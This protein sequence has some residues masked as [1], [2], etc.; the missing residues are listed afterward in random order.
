MYII[1]ADWVLR[2]GP[3][4]ND[5]YDY[6]IAAGKHKNNV[7]V[8]TRNITRFDELYDAEVQ[9]WLKEHTSSIRREEHPDGCQYYKPHDFC[10]DQN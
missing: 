10:T 9:G 1:L 5:Q 6:L 3:V 4:V 2:L 7:F 8:R